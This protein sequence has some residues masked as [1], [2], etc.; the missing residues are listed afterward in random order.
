M[1]WFESDPI[2]AGARA[3]L[4]RSLAVAGRRVPAQTPTEQLSAMAGRL[5]P[6]IVAQVSRRWVMS[7][8]RSD[9]HR[10]ADPFTQQLRYRQAALQRQLALDLADR[11]RRGVYDDLPPDNAT[12][13]RQTTL[14]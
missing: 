5:A 8:L 12:L 4:K 6:G 2:P 7:R 11:G 14:W 3:I 13:D 10:D 1:N 9:R